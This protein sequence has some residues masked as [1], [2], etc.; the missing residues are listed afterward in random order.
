MDAPIYDYSRSFLQFTTDHSNHTPRMQ[1]EASCW[2]SG[3]GEGVE[4]FLTSD[5]I[6]ERMYSPSG[7]V[8][9]PASFFSLIA[10]RDGRF[11]MR[12]RHADAGNDVEEAHRTGERMSS[13]DGEG[14]T[15]LK[16]AIDARAASNPRRLQNYGEIREAILGNRLLAGRT[17]YRDPAG[18]LKVQLGY[19]IKTCN[20]AHG[21][22]AWQ[23]DTG[24]I[25]FPGHSV[26]GRID[27]TSLRPAFILF[28]AWNW[29]ELAV[30]ATVDLGSTRARTAHFSE[31]VRLDGVTNE[32]FSVE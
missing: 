1:L 10:G 25:V 9:R 31:I 28:N 14:A 3:E 24:P 20:I 17:A 2:L 13:H 11:L 5:C 16:I 6:S 30:Q 18:K 15:M 32:L 7:L 12:K 19:P 22:E 29:A 21:P 23:M 26:G 8:H 27:I 4:Y